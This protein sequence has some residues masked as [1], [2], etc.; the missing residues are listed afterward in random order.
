M[1]RSPATP[2]RTELQ[3]GGAMTEPT[4]RTP[5][6]GFAPQPPG[7]TVSRPDAKEPRP[8]NREPSLVVIVYRPRKWSW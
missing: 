4:T 2:N 3:R 6:S 5:G 7:E 1:L 8:S